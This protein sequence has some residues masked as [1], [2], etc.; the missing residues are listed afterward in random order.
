MASSLAAAP[1]LPRRRTPEERDAYRQGL[2]AGWRDARRFVPVDRQAEFD[3]YARSLD[4]V[5]D[6]TAAGAASH[7]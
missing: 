5:L 4:A 3:A 7:A 6:A 2:K 1:A